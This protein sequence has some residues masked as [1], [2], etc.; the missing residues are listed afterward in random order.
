MNNN[1]NNLAKLALN[2]GT[3]SDYMNAAKRASDAASKKPIG[4]KIA[5]GIIKGAAQAPGRAVQGLG[6]LGQ[7]AGKAIQGAGKVYGAL[8][9][10][11][12]AAIANRVGGAVTNIGGA[13]ASVGKTIAATPERIDNAIRRYGQ[14]YEFKQKYLNPYRE[15]IKTKYPKLSA[16]QRREI[17]IANDMNGVNKALKKAVPGLTDRDISRNSTL[18]YRQADSKKEDPVVQDLLAGK[19]PEVQKTT[20]TQ[21]SASTTNTTQQAPKVMTPAVPVTKGA[22]HTKTGVPVKPPT[23]KDELEMKLPSHPLTNRTPPNRRR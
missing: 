14:S 4:K 1:F 2:E 22:T 6:K 19:T 17:D 11:Q 8:G 23:R 10:T 7:L 9:G 12:G 3:L 18:F 5:K 16:N 13:V 15:F 20:A 21:Q